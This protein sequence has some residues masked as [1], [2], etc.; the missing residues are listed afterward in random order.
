VSLFFAPPEPYE[1]N[2]IDNAQRASPYPADRMISV[3]LPPP[4]RPIK[5]ADLSA[6]QGELSLE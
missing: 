3:A 5:K 6:A 4:D 1:A 2:R